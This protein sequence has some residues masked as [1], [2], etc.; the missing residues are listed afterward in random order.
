M[1]KL[2]R[3]MSLAERKLQ[4]EAEL[5]A[6][7]SELMHLLGPDGST[8]APTKPGHTGR[9]RPRKPANGSSTTSHE[10][11]V[12]VAQTVKRTL[13][14]R[15]PLSFADIVTEL[16]PDKKTAI[17]SGLSAAQARKEVKLV[18]GK[19]ALVEAKAR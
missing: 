16:G 7:E 15:G 19:Y 18:E 11:S 6:I 13:A 14:I 2:E 3:V 10:S 17:R 8:Q 9:G 12:P 5:A 4:A 1:S